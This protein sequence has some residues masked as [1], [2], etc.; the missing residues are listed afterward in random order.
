MKQIVVDTNVLLSFL[1]D[2]NE[3]QQNRAAA[4]FQAA[5]VGEHVLVLP[6][7]VLTE[8]VYVLLNVYAVAAAEVARTIADLLGMPGVHPHD[9]LPWNQVLELWPAQIPS[10]GDAAIAS[11]ARQ[12]RHDAVATFD[13]K[14]SRQLRRLDL[15]SLW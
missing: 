15:A 5:A 10:F 4:L 14:L 8:M 1:T 7:V 6:Q 13:L 9:E 12:G 2:R 3:E 11:V